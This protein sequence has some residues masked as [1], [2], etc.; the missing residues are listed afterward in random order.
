MSGMSGMSGGGPPAGSRIYDV[1]VEIRGTIGLATQPSEAAVGLE[2]GQGA[3]QPAGDGDKSAAV[4]TPLRVAS[5][6]PAAGSEVRRHR[7]PNDSPE[8]FV[9]HASFGSERVQPH[10]SSK[11]GPSSPRPLPE[12]WRTPS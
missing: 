10:P 7:S 3:E 9:D 8:R 1:P 2:P 12:R 11:P 6:R 5:A 4:A